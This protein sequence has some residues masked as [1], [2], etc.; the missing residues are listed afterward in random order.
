M[1]KKL[2]IISCILALSMSMTACG[3]KDSSSKSNDSSTPTVSSSAE[4]SSTATDDSANEDIVHKDSSNDESGTTNEA[5]DVISKMVETVKSAK[6]AG[7]T[8][9]IN[10]SAA[11]NA[12]YNGETT[13]QKMDE[14]MDVTAYSIFDKGAYSK[15]IQTMN[16]GNGDITTT[17]ET[18]KVNSSKLQY[19]STDGINW[20]LSDVDE[21]DEIGN[22]NNI[23]DNKE[24]FKNADVQQKDDTYIITIDLNNVSQLTNSFTGAMEGAKISGNLVIVTDKDYYPTSLSMTDVKFDTSALEN[25]IMSSNTTDSSIADDT[26]IGIDVNFTFEIK[27]NNWN[28]IDESK[29]TPSDDIISKAVS[30]DKSENSETSSK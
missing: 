3:D 21:S 6:S 27:F 15:T 30:L 7:M 20:I 1:R 8:A 23:F 4:E 19:T 29:V 17:E 26:K 14:K 16:E 24:I 9:N 22:I 5:E 11:I 25:S 12:T 10:M 18:Y 2:L 13:S 28:N